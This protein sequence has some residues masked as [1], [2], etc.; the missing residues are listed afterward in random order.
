MEF[1]HPLQSLPLFTSL[2]GADI[3][4]GIRGAVFR[5][6]V[7]KAARSTEDRSFLLLEG[8]V[9]AGSITGYAAWGA[10][11]NR[12]CVGSI[13]LNARRGDLDFVE[14]STAVTDPSFWH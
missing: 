6:H 1:T 11:N 5:M 4:V 14:I 12:Q 8:L 2:K 9:P 7:T 13:K 10:F 3:E